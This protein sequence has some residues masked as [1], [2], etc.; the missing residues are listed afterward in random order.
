MLTRRTLLG[1]AVLAGCRQSRGTVI[2]MVPKGTSNIFWKTV[3]A[4]ALSAIDGK[5]LTLDWN[6]PALETDSTRQMQIVESML[7]RRVSGIIL[8]PV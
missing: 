4:G 3:H 6:A 8:A 2:G 7:N 1:S 5:G